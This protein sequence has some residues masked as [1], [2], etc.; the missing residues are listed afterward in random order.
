MAV[1][2]LPTFFG[3]KVNLWTACT[4]EPHLLLQFF[5]QDSPVASLQVLRDSKYGFL[6]PCG[7]ALISPPKALTD[8][9][10]AAIY[11]NLDQEH[12]N[13]LN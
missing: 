8:E 1:K 2:L 6:C 4:Y 10:S 7:D 5:F 11:R 3:A 13:F 12:W 9:G